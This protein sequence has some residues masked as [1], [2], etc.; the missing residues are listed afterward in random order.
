MFHENKEMSE[1]LQCLVVDLVTIQLVVAVVVEAYLLWAYF[2]VIVMKQPVNCKNIPALGRI[3]SEHVPLFCDEKTDIRNEMVCIIIIF[4][5]IFFS[6]EMFT[7]L[8]GGDGW[9][10]GCGLEE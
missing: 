4:G 9:M 5:N 3:F 6:I 8:G 7:Q 2:V 1:N 10:I